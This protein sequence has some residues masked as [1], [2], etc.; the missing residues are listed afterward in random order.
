MEHKGKGSSKELLKLK[1]LSEEIRLNIIS[2][3]TTEPLC[4]CDILE[5]FN[6]TQPTLS[7]HMKLLT[8]SGL[9]VSKR[10]G[11]WIYYSLHEE[12]MDELIEYLKHISTNRSLPLVKSCSN[13]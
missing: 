1:A 4:A 11:K 9:V 10:K 7:Y 13:C 6:I 5:S 12:E 3:L 8:S 2:L